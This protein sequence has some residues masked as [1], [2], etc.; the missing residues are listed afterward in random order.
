MKFK[1]KLNNEKFIQVHPMPSENFLEKYYSK[2]YFKKKTSYSYSNKYSKDE[3]NNK[4]LR[5]D[6]Y[7]KIAKSFFKK[8][9]IKFLEIGCGEGFLLKSALK[10]GMN[11]TGVDYQ[12]DQLLRFNKELSKFFLRTEPKNFFKNHYN[13]KKFDIIAIQQVLEHVRNPENFVNNIKSFLNKRGIIILSVPND[14]K[15]LQ[16]LILK[17]NFVKKKYWLYPPE[18]L[19]YFNNENINFFFKKLNLKVEDVVSDF[20]IEFFLC[21]TNKNYATNRNKGKEAHNARVILDNF[22][23]SQDFKKSLNYFRSTHL[24]GLGRSMTFFLRKK[25]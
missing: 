22:I 8:D 2:V 11:I 20:P 3:L 16:K 9:K 19:N 25:I 6:F 10:S 13:K 14:F 1:Y 24:C 15:N 7:T 17:K 23:L 12:I 21:G 18:H 4:I 5:S